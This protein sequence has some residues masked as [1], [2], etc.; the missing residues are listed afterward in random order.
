MHTEEVEVLLPD[1]GTALRD[2][3]VVLDRQMLE[4]DNVA[5]EGR[6]GRLVP[7]VTCNARAPVGELTYEPLLI[8]VTVTNGID[9]ER[10][11]RIR[12]AGAA[13]IEIDISRLSG[14]VTRDGLRGLVVEQVEM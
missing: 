4:L 12:Q 6:F 3:W 11:Q 2:S 13:A 7:D 8:E 14:Q 1:S 9:D 5:L 10:L